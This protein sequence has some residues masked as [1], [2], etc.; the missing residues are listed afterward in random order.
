MAKFTLLPGV[1]IC[2][3]NIGCTRQVM[4]RYYRTAMNDNELKWIHLCPDFLPLEE[5]PLLIFK[6]F[7]FVAIFK[8]KYDEEN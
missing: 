3:G 6:L 7:F 8:K 5:D 4:L 1:D 2:C